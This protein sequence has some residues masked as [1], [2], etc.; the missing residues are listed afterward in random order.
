MDVHEREERN[1]WGVDWWRDE[2]EQGQGTS[3]LRCGSA[4]NTAVTIE[5]RYRE[6]LEDRSHKSRGNQTSEL[7]W[8]RRNR[9]LRGESRQCTHDE[10]RARISRPLQPRRPTAIRREAS[11]GSPSIE[12]GADYSAASGP[13][14]TAAKDRRDFGH[15]EFGVPCESHSA[16]LRDGS[17]KRQRK[18]RNWRLNAVSRC[19][20]RGCRHTRQLRGWQRTRPCE[21]SRRDPLA[22][23]GLTHPSNGVY[24]SYA[25]SS[26][27]RSL[28]CREQRSGKAVASS[29]LR[30]GWAS[31]FWG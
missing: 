24:D 28:L 23:S 1:E 16:A 5:K 9:C 26:Q 20:E 30:R 29:V 18:D 11:S 19:Q 31:L 7:G 27:S 6:S 17:G 3:G 21:R 13:K 12:R 14:R 22:A 25:V 10:P 8:D 15:G 4:A 2:Q